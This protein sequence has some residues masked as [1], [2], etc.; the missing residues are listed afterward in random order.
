[1]ALCLWIALLSGCAEGETSDEN[2]AISETTPPVAA[3]TSESPNVSADDIYAQLL[4]NFFDADEHASEEAALPILSCFLESPTE[5]LAAF[6]CLSSGQQAE[7]FP[8]LCNNL[9]EDGMAQF[10]ETL[11]ALY[12]TYGMQSE[13]I[14]TLKRLQDIYAQSSLFVSK[15]H[16]KLYDPL[17]RWESWILLDEEEG[18]VIESA[19][20][21]SSQ[22]I[23]LSDDTD[24]PDYFFSM[25]I[26]VQLPEP[27]ADGENVLTEYAILT[28]EQG[29]KVLS[30][31][32]RDADGS[33]LATEEC[34]E[35]VSII[36]E[37]Y[38]WSYV[39]MSQVNEIEKAQ[40]YCNED[41]LAEIT[42]SESLTQLEE[43]FS[44]ARCIGYVPKT[45]LYGPRLLL[46]R[47]DGT[48]ICMYLD[49]ENDLAWLPMSFHY[50]YGPGMEGEASINNLSKLLHIFGFSAWPEE[51]MN[52]DIDNWLLDFE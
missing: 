11:Y 10:E 16:I 38:G 8:A 47:T 51:V 23:S 28:N 41:I 30:L 45:M 3:D 50:D 18:A 35:I 42:D 29:E 24:T 2:A 40:L 22:K 19:V 34:D 48:T 49:L 17:T 39:T 4:E 14:Y 37:R 1:L 20:K 31:Q 9:T 43:L 15:P 27:N 6:Q 5:M 21:D 36:C 46:T 7:L 32:D 52:T 33:F 12:E 13:E 44:N 26:I 25:D